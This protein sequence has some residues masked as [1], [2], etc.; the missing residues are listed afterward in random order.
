M[1][2]TA[3]Q[4][5][6]ETR[7]VFPNASVTVLDSSYDPVPFDAVGKF[8]GELEDFFRKVCGDTWHTFHDCD[9]FAL[10]AVFL[11]AW[12]H[13]RARVAGAGSGEG[14][15]IGTLCYL[16]DPTNRDTGHAVNVVR[17]D[18]GLFVF[19]PQRREFFSLNQ[20]QKDSAW[21]VFYT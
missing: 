13:Y 10:G 18:R 15:P 14:C 11:A 16:T 12:K 3:A 20:A 5:H 6:E 2:L 7:R 17:T 21:H 8:F 4:L 1:T 9:N 19:E